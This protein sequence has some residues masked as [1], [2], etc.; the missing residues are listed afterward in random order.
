MTPFRSRIASK[1][2]IPSWDDSRRAT[3][4]DDSHASGCT[5][6]S[7]RSIPSMS[8][9]RAASLNVR[10]KEP[11][12]AATR[13]VTSGVSAYVAAM[14]SASATAAFGLRSARHRLGRIAA[15]VIAV[16]A[17]TALAVAA[18]GL[19]AQIE[20]LLGGTSS[21]AAAAEQLP[22]GSVVI[23]S[24][25]PGA[26]EPTAI[27]A[28]LVDRAR[29]VDGVL[30][31]SGTFEQPIAVRIE[32]GSQ[33][34]R[35]PMLRG[36]VFSSEW[37]PLRWRVRN[38]TDPAS[39][40]GPTGDG[41]PLP[42]SMDS[43][44]LRTADA[45]VGDVIRLQTPTG[46]RDALVVGEVVP[47]AP[48]DADGPG[49]PSVSGP[50]GVADAHIVVERSAL[51][52]VLG[53]RGR[54]DRITVTPVP[55]VDTTDLV[56]A[57]SA[58]LPDDLVLRSAADP[59]V[60]LARSVSAVSGTVV[61]ATWALAL[62]ASIVA[63]MLI[64]NTLSIVAAQRSLETALARCIGMSRR[65]V[66]ASFLV[67]A[68]A[69]GSAAALLGIALG[70][71]LAAVAARV[72]FPGVELDLF[73]TPAMAAAALLVGFGVTVLAATHPAIGLARVPPMVAVGAARA[74]RG[75]SVMLSGL[76]PILAGL[77]RLTRRPIPRMSLAHPAQDP[78]R[79]GAVVATLFLSLTLVSA[80]LTV[81]TTV[82]SS[83]DDQ[84]AE[85]STADLYL[86][87]RGVVRVDA[88]A[89]EARL[90][91]EGRAGYVDLSRVEGSLLGPDGVESVLRS[92]GLDEIPAAF[93]LDPTGT[94]GG[95]V[96]PGDGAADDGL[97][98]SVLVS[99]AAA[100]NLGTDVGEAVTLRTTSGE[101]IELT[102]RAT[103]RNAGLVGPVLVD[104]SAVRAVD[105]EGTLELVAIRL[106]AGAPVEQVRDRI[107]RNIGGF[108]RLAVDTPER[109]AAT[110]SDIAA[111]V[112]R[113]VL[114]LLAGTLALGAVGAAN[115]IALS[116]DERRR[117]LS[118]LRAVGARRSQV[119]AVVT[120]EAV[121]LCLVV[122]VLAA[123]LG[124]AL[125]AVGVHLAP[126][127]L[128]G[129]AVVPWPS[130][131]ALVVGAGALG[132][133]AA[134]VPAAAAARRP[135]LAGVGE[136]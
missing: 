4:A 81:S 34:E 61:A 116:V 109:I 69:I 49:D 46:G 38:G 39:H 29:E 60:A 122:G 35:P 10:T 95:A 42:V 6:Q 129:A 108:N 22:E 18:F 8:T 36:L 48:I 32:R 127:E 119:L 92:G 52:D 19:A 73:V 93:P 76:L 87:R 51:A 103:Y 62:V 111:T 133:L 53:A 132:L 70:A 15:T 40:L 100:R 114:V 104:R 106:A 128:V 27:S 91:A 117:E 96:A 59:D 23:T 50:G 7:V 130:L 79:A 97:V 135:P 20:A 88:R 17:A 43:A 112:T 82:R 115:N 45:E 2:M 11:R 90:G 41:A 47:A 65:Q 16:G 123:G 68:G 110:D 58:A 24:G 126:G 25:A 105:A 12:P 13:G 94:G 85:R 44:G 37:D 21:A 26:T 125:A 75:H 89:L 99:E 113:L 3:T 28:G 9:V 67:E 102:V 80:V 31:A 72:V 66:A 134:A 98:R 56:D 14:S 55:G 77:R 1:A 120:T 86:R 136:G 101:D 30:S 83:I 33:D 121:V 78:R 71:A 5:S 57:L 124:V 64:S 54:V 74:R 107:D 84:F 63:A 131:G 118:T